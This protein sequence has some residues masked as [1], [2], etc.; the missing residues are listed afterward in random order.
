MFELFKQHYLVKLFPQCARRLELIDIPR[1]QAF[2]FPSCPPSALHKLVS[3]L[4]EHCVDE[5]KG[6][7]KTTTSPACPILKT[8]VLGSP[9]NREF[10]HDIIANALSLPIQDLQNLESARGA[11]YILAVWM[12]S[13]DNERPSFLRRSSKANTDLLDVPG[14]SG[15]GTFAQAN[16]YL[17][18]YFSMLV[19]VLETGFESY[20]NN[21]KQEILIREVLSIFRAVSQNGTI[22]LEEETW[23]SL[24]VLL[25]NS[26]IV[27]AT[28]AR[29]VPNCD[30]PDDLVNYFIETLFFVWGRSMTHN[31]RLWSKL[32]T[33]ILKTPRWIQTV[34]QWRSIMNQLVRILGEV[35]YETDYEHRQPRKARPRP[36]SIA[37]VVRK[38]SRPA[39]SVVEAVGRDEATLTVYSHLSGTSNDTRR[40]QNDANVS[41]RRSSSHLRL[42]NPDLNS[43][44]PDKSHPNENAL[45]S[46]KALMP[47]FT[48]QQIDNTSP[49][50]RRLT[51]E[52]ANIEDSGF[53][54]L[55]TLNWS[56]EA[57]ASMW[58]NF[59]HLLGNP[60]EITD[61]TAHT[62]AIRCLVEMWDV[63]AQIRSEQAFTAPYKPNLFEFAPWIFQASEM[64][65]VFR[66]GH[67]LAF[68]CV[69]RMLCHLQEDKIADVYY[70]NFYRIL[71][72]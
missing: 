45:A 9:A 39:S 35:Y 23:E 40:I 34:T 7:P 31:E 60:N 65:S 44:N 38:S 42:F 16:S 61:P 36:A 68:G 62:N 47:V 21:T 8:I 33:E 25:V 58:K 29:E 37:V 51:M 18:Q 3:F 56:K 54:H 67:L 20:N 69:C 14:T 52:F 10:I 48:D 26:F 59:L 19:S 2:G 12:L 46:L 63:L 57:I 1:D 70:A 32:N 49:I 43:T 24:L 22:Q 11:A 6:N 5:L 28:K 50:N 72:R 71:L 4:V 41:V 27:F 30:L 64:S 15:D 13:G 55:S 17:R 53:T 66:E